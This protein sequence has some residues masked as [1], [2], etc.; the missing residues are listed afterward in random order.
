MP[1]K[2]NGNG[3]N[4]SPHDTL[5]LADEHHPDFVDGH[6]DDGQPQG[7]TPNPDGPI[8]LPPLPPGG[9]PLPPFPRPDLPLP[10]RPDLPLP[11]PQ[12][13]PPLNICTSVSGRYRLA[14][15]TPISPNPL[16][17]PF[18]GPVLP[19]PVLPLNLTRMTVRVD[20]DRFT[21]QQRISVEVWRLFP[22]RRAHVIAEVTSDQCLGF[23]NRRVT[24]SISYRDGDASLFPGTTLVFEARRTTGRGYGRYRLTV[25]GGG[26]ATRTH[27][28]AFESRYFDSMEFEV[29]RVS[30]AVVPSTSVNTAA[31]PNRPADLPAETLGIDTIFQRAGFDARMSPNANVIPVGEAGANGTWSDAEMHNAMVAH[32]SRFANRP[33]WAMWVL[34]AAR[35]DS[36]RGL[37]G[38]MFDDIGPN[39]RQGTAIFT[40]SFIQDAPAGDPNPAAWRQRMLFWTAIHEIGHG[41]NL[42][43]SWQKSLGT[44]WIPLANE[45]E[46]RSFMNYPFRVSGGQASFFADFRYR[47]SDSE[48]QFMRHAPRRFVQMGNADWFVNHAFEAPESLPQS[49]RWRLAIRPNRSHNRFAFLEPVK[50]ELKLTN[51]SDEA[52]PVEHDLLADGKHISLI[53][54]RK[55]A[56]AR[57]W[58][59]FVTRCERHEAAMLAPGQ[60]IYGEQF[61]GATTSGWL[62][63]EPGLYQIQAAVDVGGDIIVSNVLEIMVGTPASAEAERLAPD[64]FSEDVA[65]VLAFDGAPALARATSTVQELADRLP[66]SAAAIHAGMALSAP[67]L[68]NFKVLSD[69]DVPELRV[70]KADVAAGAKAQA[71]L[72]LKAPER[73]ADTLGHIDYFAALDG[74][75]GTLKAADEADRAASVLSQSVATMKARGVLKSVIDRTERSLARLK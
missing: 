34:F 71:D 65:R 37:G 35:H 61:A 50:L 24:A 27:E 28:L 16:P 26:A 18:P 48:L 7:F 72:L 11:I 54:A 14:Q 12:P 67:L 47:F 75:A 63:D 58:A 60:S 17:Q 53:I 44:P 64:W 20:V 8:P 25:S 15:P 46:A 68:R 5:L 62:I 4:H 6:I 19:G 22:Q 51:S 52:Q 66:D 38:I 13:F 2:T 74:L 1:K 69:D 55:G 49:G 43:H 40:D 23:N 21:P 41:F 36:G 39:H 3:G 31:H 33:N 29:D 57:L 42:A 73:A 56:P 9:G 10:V 70:I 59:P 32:W 45:P 30:N